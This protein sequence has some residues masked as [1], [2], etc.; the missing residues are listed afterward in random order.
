M[1]QFESEK[2]TFFK[3]WMK[4]DW[5]K[6]S[7]YNLTQISDWIYKVCLFV[8][9]LEAYAFETAELFELNF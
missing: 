7:T 8:C 4:K 3:T 6:D 5:K 9:F 2:K 1:A